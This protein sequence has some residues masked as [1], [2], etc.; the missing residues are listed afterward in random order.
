MHIFLKD[1]GHRKFGR[2]SLIAVLLTVAMTVALSGCFR[3]KIESSPPNRRPVVTAKAPEP[4]ASAPVVVEAEKKPD[5]IEETYVVDAPEQPQA[6]RVQEGELGEEPV[7]DLA[8]EG[9]DPGPT[10][11]TAEPAETGTQPTEPE[12][13]VAKASMAEAAA[14]EPETADVEEMGKATAAGMHFVQVGAFSDVENANR[15]LAYLLSEGYQGSTLSKSKDG[16]FRVRAG[17]FNDASSAREALKALQD[18]YP[19][20]Y[21]VA[22]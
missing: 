2:P 16:L 20:S 5:L 18:A 6:I 17:A 8:I 13:E 12:P 10:A 9:A 3:K 7:V 19:N 21:V 4:K 15:A 1:S 11:N 22:P 14:T